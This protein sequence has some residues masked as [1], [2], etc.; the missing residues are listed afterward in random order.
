MAP[1]LASNQESAELSDG[2][3]IAAVLAGDVSRFTLLVRRHNL[4]LFRAC[5]AVLRDDAEAEAEVQAAC[6]RLAAVPLEDATMPSDVDPERAVRGRPAC[7]GRREAPVAVP[8]AVPAPKPAPPDGALT[9]AQVAAITY[10]CTF[11]PT[12][13]ARLTV[14]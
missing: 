10:V 4:V 13:T 14:R 7:N 6:R 11:H 9:A 3:A 1:K 8:A 5:R 12:M 2:E